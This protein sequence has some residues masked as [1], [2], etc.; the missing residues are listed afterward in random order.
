MNMD[1]HQGPSPSIENGI[2]PVST[3]PVGLLNSTPGGTLMP[4]SSEAQSSVYGPPD[5]AVS[6][7][8]AQTFYC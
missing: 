5:A 7:S 1:L 3:L 8:T 4:A 2:V 6:F